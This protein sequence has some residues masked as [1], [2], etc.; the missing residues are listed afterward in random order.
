MVKFTE[1]LTEHF[2]IMEVVAN[3]K[4][5]AANSEKIAKVLQKFLEP[6]FKLKND[7][8]LN[9]FLTHLVGKN[10]DLQN[11]L[12][13]EHKQEFFKW[14]VNACNLWDQRQVTPPSV[15]VSFALHLASHLC[16]EE[17]M[18][19]GLNSRNVFESLVGIAQTNFN[20]D[21]SVTLGYVT[22]LCAFLE[23]KSGLQW[24][25]AT[26][27]WSEVVSLGRNAHTM[28]IRKKSYQFVEK[29]LEKTICF[30]L[31]FCGNLAAM[32]IRP[33]SDA[34]KT[35]PISKSGQ[36]AAIES[37]TLY[38]SLKPSL[39]FISEV[40]EAL[41]RGMQGAVLNLFIALKLGELTAKLHLLS[42]IEDFSFELIKIRCIL[43]FAKISKEAN[44]MKRAGAT[45]IAHDSITLF[46]MKTMFD[47]I[48]SEMDKD[49]VKCVI[50]ICHYAH[51][52]HYSLAEKMPL[53]IRKGEP[54]EFQNQMVLFQIM[55]IMVF[56][57][58]G[59]ITKEVILCDVFRREFIQ[60]L[61]KLS[62]IRTVEIC[63]RW[64]QR[65][66][67]KQDLIEDM[68]FGLQ[69]MVKTK[70][71]LNKER[72]TIFFQPLV[73]A[74]KD[75]LSFLESYSAYIRVDGRMKPSFVNF[76]K[77]LIE[78]IIDLV[79]SFDL[80]WKDS[81]ETISVLSLACE[82][83]G[84]PHLE[85][86]L[87]VSGLRLLNLA[88]SKYMA[89]DLVLLLDSTKDSLISN[90]GTL[91]YA[92]CLETDW[93]I[94]D[95][96]LEN[97]YT[98]SLNANTKFPSYA[99]II[100]DAGLPE[101][102]FQMALNDREYYVRGTAFRC[103]HQLIQIQAAWDVFMA[104]DRFLEKI[105]N[106]FDHETEGV[107]RKE[108]VLLIS[109]IYKFQHFPEELLPRVYDVMTHAVTGDLHWEVKYNAL[110][111][112]FDVFEVHLNNQ[113]MI[114]RV[115]PAVT[116]SKEQRKIVT[117]NETEIR[118][119]LIKALN[120]LSHTG[121]LYVLKTAFLDDCDVQVSKKAANAVS[122]MMKLL[123]MY[124][125][126]CDHIDM[127]EPPSPCVQT[128]NIT[129]ASPSSTSSIPSPEMNAVSP[130]STSAFSPQVPTS[131]YESLSPYSY[132]VSSPSNVEQPLPVSVSPC[133]DNNPASSTFPVEYGMDYVESTLTDQMVAINHQTH[134]IIPEEDVNFTRD[135][136]FDPQ[137]VELI[138][139]DLLNS[140]DLTFLQKIYSPNDQVE[141]NACRMQTKM[142]L[143]PSEFLTF[144]YQHAETN[145][146]EKT[147]WL[148][149]LDEFD[150]LLD[151]I[152]KE[153]N[154]V[155]DVNSMDC[156]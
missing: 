97:I 37:S 116:F 48:Q 109:K 82:F 149:S 132:P 143:A 59:G 10:S 69:Y 117:L 110:D 112:W 18:F 135:S 88:V 119:R 14:L 39:V 134:N 5:N 152:L 51:T 28:Y 50:R 148:S 74:F 35:L 93:E 4:N 101:F 92:K 1:L 8:Y 126:P 141:N 144:V 153:Y 33:L 15:I 34:L 41:V 57:S 70:K 128:N 27:H 87:V 58:R 56:F 43:L 64:K 142:Y 3:E 62:A 17:Q 107:V 20:K 21:A 11:P 25:L 84:F 67:E 9:L 78:T 47:I 29:L 85:K 90:T 79:Q 46:D 136:N 150:S 130:E 73:Y 36:H 99:N 38:E 140:S 98:L 86:K 103:L 121:C 123:K 19:V 156:Y 23:H 2:S 95:T 68:I 80:T 22:M 147:Q 127:S 122:K 94:R 65:L 60:K 6:N 75:T 7:V 96:A 91:L 138:M 120:Q 13:K 100:V 104:A 83:L 129:A 124:H 53:C 44:P 32:L 76:V 108:A 139:D 16:L 154:V 131:L 30:N 66:L 42:Q 114:D 31:Q 24:V 45:Q 40:M 115:F 12:T 155:P 55:P 145:F 102:V 106:V 113:G 111:F 133:P 137:Q 26:T 77:T 63:F 52:L 54:I 118:R 105:L 61:V 125:V 72:A 151:D 146:K 81:I 49:H 71:L 89:P